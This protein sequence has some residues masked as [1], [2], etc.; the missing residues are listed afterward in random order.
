[1]RLLDRYL[2]RELFIPLGYCL[3]GFLIFYIAF[4]LIASLNH[5]QEQHLQ[6]RDVLEYYLVKLPDIIVFIL[7]V[8]LLLA[9]LYTLTNHARHHELTAIR[10]AGVSLWRLCAPYLVVGFLFSVIA[11][12][13]NELRVPDSEAKQFEISHRHTGTP[14]ATKPT[15]GSLGFYNKRDGRNWI[16]GSY[17]FKTDVMTDPQVYWSEHGT[18]FHLVAKHAERVNDVWTFYDATTFSPGDPL[19]VPAGKLAMPQFSETPR[20]FDK[21]ARFAGRFQ[22]KLSADSVEMPIREIL[23]YLDHPDLSAKDERWLRTQL[24]RRFAEPW[25]SFVVV[26]IAIPFGAASGRRNIFMGVAGSIVICFV[27]FILL[28]VGLA[29]GTGGYLP[30]WIAAWLPN[31]FFGITGFWLMLR[32]R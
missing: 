23:D 16:I 30:G 17:N 32:V 9:L 3:C 4:D 26:L 27:Y 10:A 6:L 21:E 12:A 20:Q 15:Q 18:N 28:K 7:P 29:L 13:L 25:S 8:T 14:G 19:G 22:G 5:F 24:H 11:I 31:A 1:M 2:L